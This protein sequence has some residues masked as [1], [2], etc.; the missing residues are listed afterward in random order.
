VPGFEN[1]GNIYKPGIG[2]Y[3]ED[4]IVSLTINRMRERNLI[5]DVYIRPNARVREQIGLNNYLG[6]NERPANLD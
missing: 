4:E 3:S 2:P 5:N 6:L 1:Q